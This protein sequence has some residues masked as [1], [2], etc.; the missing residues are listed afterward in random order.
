MLFLR[1]CLLLLDALDSAGLTGVNLAY[2][3][4][5]TREPLHM[6]VAVPVMRRAIVILDRYRVVMSHKSA[7]I[8]KS[9]LCIWQQLAAPVSP[10]IDAYLV[11]AFSRWLTIVETCYD[12]TWQSWVQIPQETFFF[13]AALILAECFWSPRSPS[14]RTYT[15][16]RTVC[17]QHAA[18]CP[19][20]ERPEPG[21]YRELL[22]TRRLPAV[23]GICAYCSSVFWKVL[24]L[25][26]HGP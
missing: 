11:H 20:P 26:V 5:V 2:D 19:K 12:A 18:R 24:F 4:F 9:M 16:T 3:V 1:H 6:H 15:V 10:C 8:I 21:G 7:I 23:F 13:H 22:E 14:A 25:V 17:E